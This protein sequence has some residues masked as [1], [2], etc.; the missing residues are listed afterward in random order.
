MRSSVLLFMAL[1]LFAMP[2]M[3]SEHE[4]VD[5]DYCV[6]GDMTGAQVTDLYHAVFGENVTITGM[7]ANESVGYLNRS[8]NTR[9]WYEIMTPQKDDSGNHNRWVVKSLDALMARY[10]NVDFALM[11]KANGDL[12]IL[13]MEKEDPENVN[14][15]E[16]LYFPI[17]YYYFDNGDAGS[18]VFPSVYYED[19]SSIA[20]V[21]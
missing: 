2:C 12:W 11:T 15:T 8:D 1:A 21:G 7:P 13:A 3:A 16:P 19:V 6:K 4:Y 17:V 10:P 9:I 18:Q 5:W 20:W 14:G